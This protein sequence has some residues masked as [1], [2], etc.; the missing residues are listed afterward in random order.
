[1]SRKPKGVFSRNSSSCLKI[2]SPLLSSNLEFGCNDSGV[3]FSQGFLQ[4]IPWA[5]YTHPS[6]TRI[7]FS[8]RKLK[9]FIQTLCSLKRDVYSVEIFPGVEQNEKQMGNYLQTG[10]LFF[11]CLLALFCLPL[12]VLTR[13]TSRITPLQATSS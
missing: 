10:T 8:S 1:M 7:Q 5:V 4:G 3:A 6:E 2:L 12:K 13:N 11:P 9:A